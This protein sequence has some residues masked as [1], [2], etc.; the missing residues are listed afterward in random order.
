MG[1]SVWN[2][3]NIALTKRLYRGDSD[4]YSLEK[5]QPEPLYFNRKQYARATHQYQLPVGNQI[6]DLSEER[7]LDVDGDG[8]P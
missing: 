3:T 7:E 2:F 4:Y 5:M 1:A 8:N 6:L